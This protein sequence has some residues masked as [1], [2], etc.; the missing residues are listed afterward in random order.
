MIMARPLA[1]FALVFTLLGGA[2]NAQTATTDPR[3]IDYAAWRSV[4]ERAESAISDALA[5][6]EAFE[7]LRSEIVDW[8]EVFLIGQQANAERIKTLR[9]QIDALGP[10]PAEGEAEPEE[11]AVRRTE[12][13]T[14]LATARAPV[15]SAIEAFSRADGL[16]RE[17]DKIIRERQANALLEL[18]SSP[19]NPVNWPGAIRD[20][21]ATLGALRIE[22]A[23]AWES[24]IRREALRSKLAIT[25]FLLA[26]ALGL[27][28]FGEVFMY[29][30]TRQA[31]ARSGPRGKDINGFLVSMGQVM[32]PVLGMQLLIYVFQSSGMVGLRGLAIAESLPAFALCF[33]GS[34]WLGRRLFPASEH[35]YSPVSAT[36]E[37]SR[38]LRRAT[39]FV[40][41]FIGLT[42]IISSLSLF[43]EH[44]EAT[45]AILQFPMATLAAFGLIR[46]GR[47]LAVLPAPLSGPDGSAYGAR[48]VGLIGK[49]VVL[50][51]V[52]SIIAAA[53]GYLNAAFFVLLP[54]AFSIALLGFLLLLNDPIRDLYALV[55]GATAEEAKGA[56]LPTL[57]NFMMVLAAIPVFA[58]I[59]GAR[60]AD[61]TE[62]W[63]L[64]R[65]GFQLGETRVSPTNF[66][67]FVLVFLGLYIAT[68]L[69]QGTLRNNILPKTRMD[70]GGQN[71]IV[72]GIG[73]VG[74]FLAALA[75]IGTAG[76][77]LSS[78][79]I[80]AGALSV[81]IGF[82]LQNIV[83]N[84]VSGIILLIERPVA[85][86]DWI[87]VG[88]YM[89]TVKK[90]SVRSTL[91]E[92]FDRTDVI[93]PNGDFISGAVTNWTRTNLIGRVKVP[94]GVAYGTDTRKVTQILTDIANE[95]P[96]VTVDPAPGVDFLG[97]GADSMDFQIRAVLS[98][99]NYSVTVRTEMNHRIAERFAEEGIEIPFAQ[100]DV[101]LRNPETLRGG[102]A[103]QPTLSPP[104]SFDPGTAHQEIDAALGSGGD[105][106][107]EQT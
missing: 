62:I 55:T 68:R 99:V 47:I 58:L 76:I 32:L 48:G 19:L 36:P 11:I 22:I 102:Q 101:W 23:Q 63:A 39:S 34:R 71:A 14:Q 66:L 12:L 56:L 82:G 7:V 31:I 40:G 90:I 16:A 106:G 13:S 104:S 49:A 24:Q 72:S 4:A 87:E 83:Q 17:I 18:G 65:K 27:I 6:N 95:H 93:V 35:V 105:D 84:F 74:I 43:E 45:T 3:A 79:A 77:D 29:G 52:I 5:S 33:F 42:L 85:E 53:V 38:K 20:T 8:R 78:L 9:A 80:V 69:V 57:I 67:V 60:T 28:F 92:T 88:G 94:V 30:V 91:V 89:G 97:F 46:V 44:I 25:L 98:D 61:L 1:L 59:W 26:L 51:S 21:T 54:T 86:G 64:F 75:A 70:T 41:L 50:L 37:Q 10:A 15:I 107:G 2:L 73:Y 81:G 103:A 100:R 96:L